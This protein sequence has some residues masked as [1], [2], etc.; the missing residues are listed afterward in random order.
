MLQLH[1]KMPKLTVNLQQVLDQI[2]YKGGI[3]A[4]DAVCH[5]MNPHCFM[6]MK[7]EV[8]LSLPS[9]T[10]TV[11]NLLE[12]VHSSFSTCSESLCVQY[13]MYFHIF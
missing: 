5:I 3:S 7:M 4:N 8:V 10:D 2:I 1:S 6:T 13:V 11:V 12:R 9:V